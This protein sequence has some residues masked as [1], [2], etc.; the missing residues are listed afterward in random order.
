MVGTPPP[1]PTFVKRSLKP[2]AQVGLDLSSS[3]FSKLYLQEEK[4]MDPQ[5]NLKPELWEDFKRKL[6]DKSVRCC[7]NNILLIADD[8]GK[9]RNI[10]TE[11]SL[12]TAANIQAAQDDIWTST[13]TSNTDQCIQQDNR[14]K[15]QLLATYLLESLT[16]SAR[17]TIDRTKTIWTFTSDGETFRHGPAILWNIAQEVKP[18]NGHLV[19]QNKITLRKIHVKDYGF[20]IKAMLTEFDI[21]SEDIIDLGGSYDEEE[22]QIDFWR[23]VKTME[24]KRKNGIVMQMINT[25]LTVSLPVLLVLPFPT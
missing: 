12:L 13:K 23:A 24:E 9:D 10:I 11:Y 3:A 8:N 15:S 14:I 17:K 16:V 6:L 19:D 21:L 4:P 20:S 7:L 5:Y 18:D 22:K 1:S 2:W 25:I